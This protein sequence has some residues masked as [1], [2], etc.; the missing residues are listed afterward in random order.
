LLACLK[1]YRALGVILVNVRFYF[2]LFLLLLSLFLQCWDGT[3]CHE[4]ARELLYRWT[5]SKS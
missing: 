2:V 5:T 4:N 1:I 3:Q